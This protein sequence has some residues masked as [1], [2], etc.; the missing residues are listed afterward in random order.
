MATTGPPPAE[1]NTVHLGSSAEPSN[2]SED[3]RQLLPPPP[4]LSIVNDTCL[5]GSSTLPEL[6]RE[7]NS[8]RCW[9]SPLTVKVVTNGSSSSVLSCRVKA[10]PSIRYS[11]H[12]TPVPPV[13]SVALS[14]TSTGPSPSS[15]D[16]VVGAA[17]SLPTITSTVRDSSS[18]SA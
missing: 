10:P 13:P 18:P 3:G 5:S 4:S 14:V 8:T 17:V 9:P 6:S 2:S 15:D 11:V 7:R 16:V 12:S 1:R